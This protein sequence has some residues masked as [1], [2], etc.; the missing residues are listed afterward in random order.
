[1][2]NATKLRRYL[3]AEI[4][5]MSKVDTQGHWHPLGTKTKKP[6]FIPV[7]GLIKMCRK[8]YRN[9]YKEDR[10][11]VYTVWDSNHKW[12]FCNSTGHW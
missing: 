6:K 10:E 4:P 2:L 1:V 5:T 3:W 8:H 9:V 11:E 7:D 12:D